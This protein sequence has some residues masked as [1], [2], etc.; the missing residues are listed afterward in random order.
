MASVWLCEA[1]HYVKTLHMHE[2]I[3]AGR[4]KK[5]AANLCLLRRV[6]ESRRWRGILTWVTYSYLS[7]WPHPLLH[8]I[9]AAKLPSLWQPWHHQRAG[10]QVL[11]ERGGEWKEEMEDKKES[12]KKGG[13]EI[14]EGVEERKRE[15]EREILLVS[16]NTLASL[17]YVTRATAACRPVCPIHPCVSLLDEVRALGQHGHRCTSAVS[18]SPSTSLRSPLSFSH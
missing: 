16:V 7:P 13:V 10:G 8:G 17:Q 11:F 15:R 5:G 6:N 1:G 12:A 18:V 9:V 4:K 2:Q 14:R 3:H